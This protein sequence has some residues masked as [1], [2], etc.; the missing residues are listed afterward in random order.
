MSYSDSEYTS[1]DDQMNNLDI[2]NDPVELCTVTFKK[3]NKLL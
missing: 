3:D 1:N 2:S